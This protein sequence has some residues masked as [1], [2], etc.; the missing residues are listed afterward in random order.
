MDDINPAAHE[1]IQQVDTL[2]LY[3]LTFRGFLD[4]TGEEALRF[5][6]S[7]Y[8][9]QDWMKNIPLYA[10]ANKGLWA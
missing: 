5:S 2:D 6:L 7:P 9:D 10:M 1:S 8:R 4:A 3:P